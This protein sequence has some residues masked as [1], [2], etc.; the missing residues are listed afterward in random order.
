MV[1]IAVQLLLCNLYTILYIA[2][3]IKSTVE[4]SPLDENTVLF[5]ENRKPLG[6]VGFSFFMQNDCECES[7]EYTSSEESTN[8]LREVCLISGLLLLVLAL[9]VRAEYQ[10]QL[11]IFAFQSHFS[12]DKVLPSM[13]CIAEIL[14]DDQSK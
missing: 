7:L 13:C 14:N 10:V 4:H 9:R 2:V 5:F 8:I 3:V 1:C 11:H 12:A 6:K